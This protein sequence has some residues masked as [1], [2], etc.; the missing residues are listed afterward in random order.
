MANLLHDLLYAARGLRKA[1]G[2]AVTAILTLALGI[3]AT[4]A[5]FSLLDAVLLRP[6]PF[7]EPGRL[8]AI[9]ER[10]P[11]YLRNTV[12]TPTYLDWREQNH[13]FE[14]MGAME[15]GSLTI[16]GDGVPARLSD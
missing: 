7:P 14:N 9:S 15:T 16:T 13:T 11:H 1:P 5:I 2:F 12:S 4:S 6:L 3:G 8:V 10:P